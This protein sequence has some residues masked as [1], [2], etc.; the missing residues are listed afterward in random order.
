MRNNKGYSLAELLISIAI[1]S[2]VMVGIVTI[3]KNVSISYRNENAEV[4]LQENSQILLS[5]MEE[6]LIDCDKVEGSGTDTSPYKITK[7]SG[8]DS[9]HNPIVGSTQYL[10]AIPVLDSN[11]NPV[12][13]GRKTIQ[14]KYNTSGYEDLATDVTDFSIT[15]IDSTNGDN[16]CLVK[17]TLI[18]NLDGDDSGR[19]YEYEASKVVVFRNDVEKAAV[20]NSDFLTSGGGGGGTT[21]PPTPDTINAVIGRYQLVN[22]YSEYN[23]KPGSTITMTSNGTAGYMFVDEAYLDG[24]NAMSEI[25]ESAD[26]TGY[27]TTNSTCNSDTDDPYSC[28]IKF[29]NN[30]NKV[31]TLNVTTPKVELKKGTGIIYIPTGAVQSSNGNYYSYLKV[32]GICI[33]DLK[34]YYG[35]DCTATVK[36]NISSNT[37]GTGKIFDCTSKTEFSNNTYGSFSAHSNGQLS[38]AYGLGYDPYSTDTLGF[39]IYDKLFENNESTTSFNNAAKKAQ[40]SITYPSGTSTA[41]TPY[42]EY[43]L[44]TSGATLSGLSN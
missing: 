21:N 27:F 41:S 24:N 8:Y 1:F 42:V 9:N 37:Q 14:Y 33:R 10:K 36:T 17:V 6:L 19:K 13:S 5:Q 3:M 16:S 22:L 2:I 20:H 38:A 30:D 18:N 12:T 26:A 44:Y 7:Y 29:T 39:V 23:C 15:G 40:I 35:T 4:Q 31:I 11:G 25:H 28:T 32:S 43:I 34:K